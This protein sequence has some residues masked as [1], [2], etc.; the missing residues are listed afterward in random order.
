[1]GGVFSHFCCHDLWYLWSPTRRSR[2]PRYSDRSDYV[3]DEVAQQASLP[4]SSSS[5]PPI[6]RED[7][8]QYDV[9][10]S[11]R[12]PDTRYGFIS[13]LHQALEDK[14]IITFIDSEGLEKGR[15]VDELFGYIERSKIFVP[16]FSKGYANS[17][18]CLKEI[19]KIMECKRLV[20]PVFFHVE[21]TDVRHQTGPF[22]D[23][24]RD[25]LEKEKI[26]EEEV[27]N[28]RSALKEAGKISGH[29]LDAAA[30]ERTEAKVV[31]LICKRVQELIGRVPFGVQPIGIDS[32]I[33][34][35]IM[36][37]RAQANGVCK[38]GICG[39]GGIGKTTTAKAIYDKLYSEFDGGSFIQDIREFAERKGMEAV[40]EK[41]IRDV[42]KQDN[43]Q[44][45]NSVEQGRVIIKQRLERKRVLIILDNIVNPYQLEAL[46]GDYIAHKPEDLFGEGSKIIVTARDEAI[47][48]GFGL[49]GH[50]IYYPQELK[51]PWSLKLFHRHAF[52]HEQ[53]PP[54]ALLKLAEEAT[55]IAGGLPLVLELFGKAFSGLKKPEEWKNELKNLRMNPPTDIMKNLRWSYDELDD[56]EKKV[57]LDIACFLVGAKRKLVAYLWDDI[58][59]EDA[60]LVLQ[61][62]SLLSVDDEDRFRM[63][64]R[65]QEMGR[66]IAGG[67]GNGDNCRLCCG[68][69]TPIMTMHSEEKEKVQGIVLKMEAQSTSTNLSTKEF[70]GMYNLRLLHLYHVSFHERAEINHFPKK[71]KWLRWQGCPLESVVFNGSSFMN[72]AI[73]ELSECIICHLKLHKLN[74]LKVLNLSNCE[75]LQATPDFSC[76][77]NLEKLFLDNC[78]KLSDIHESVC[79][80]ESL[81]TWSMRN[82]ESVKKLPEEHRC[83]ISNLSKL[84]ELNLQGCEKIGSL[85]RLPSSLKVLVLKGCKML[86]AVHGFDNL[87]FIEQLYM[88]GCRRINCNLMTRLF[89]NKT[90]TYLEELSISGS[91]TTP[92]SEKFLLAVPLCSPSSPLLLDHLK[93]YGYSTKPS[94][95]SNIYNKVCVKDMEDNQTIY[96]TTLSAHRD[97]YDEIG[98]SL[99]YIVS[100]SKYDDINFFPNLYGPRLVWVST[101]DSF[102]LTSVDILLRSANQWNKNN[103]KLVHVHEI[104]ANLLEE[105][106]PTFEYRTLEF[107]VMFSC[108]DD[109]DRDFIS[110]ICKVLE[111]DGISCVLQ[112]KN[113]EES[114]V[115]E[116]VKCIERSA[117]CVPIFSKQFIQSKWCLD[118]IAKMIECEKS[119]MPIYFHVHPSEVISRV[120]YEMKFLNHEDEGQ[121]EIFNDWR[122]VLLA[123]FDHQFIYE[124]SSNVEE[125]M[126][127]V[128]DGISATLNSSAFSLPLTGIG[129]RVNDVMKMV[130]KETRMVGICGE[131]GIGKTAIAKAMYDQRFHTSVSDVFI[132]HVGDLARTDP[133][134]SSRNDRLMH[135][136]EDRY[137][138]NLM[139]NSENNMG[140]AIFD[141]ADGLD[142]HQS[143][144]MFG[145]ESL[146]GEGT[147][148]IIIAKD[149]N[150]LYK[151]GLSDENIYSVSKLN[152]KQ[153]LRLF[154]YHAFKGRRPKVEIIPMAW[155]ATQF[156]GGLPL[157]LKVLVSLFSGL[158]DENEWKSILEK[159]SRAPGEGVDK[160]LEVSIGSL[161]PHEQQV[162]FDIAFLNE[163]P[164][165]MWKDVRC[166][167]GNTIEFLQQRCLISVDAENMPRMHDL[168]R[169][170][171]R[172][173]IAQR[174]FRCLR[175]MITD[176]LDLDHLH[177]IFLDIACCLIGCE[178]EFATYMWE[179][180]GYSPAHAI[181]VLHDRS[182][183][184]VDEKGRL[185]M[186]DC[187][188]DVGT[189]IIKKDELNSCSHWNENDLLQTLGDG[190]ESCNDKIECINA[191]FTQRQRLV[192]MPAMG[193][194]R[195]LRLSNCDFEY[196]CLRSDLKNL[197]WLRMEMCSVTSRVLCDGD[198]F[199]NLLVLQLYDCRMVK[200]NAVGANNELQKV[201][202][203]AHHRKMYYQMT[204]FHKLKVL[205]IVKCKDVES[206]SLHFS[207][208][209]SLVKLVIDLEGCSKWTES[210]EDLAALSE[211]ILSDSTME[212]LPDCIFKLNQLQTFCISD[213]GMLK[214]L[215]QLPGSLESLEL[216][217]CYEI[218]ELPPLPG[219][220]KTLKIKWCR[221]S[222]LPQLPASL[223]TL[224]LQGCHEISELP[225][226]PGSLKTLKIKWCTI[227]HLPQL[228]SSLITLDT[229]HCFNLTWMA[230]ISGLRDL[231]I[232]NLCGCVKLA[233]VPGLQNLK[234][235]PFITPPSSYW[236]A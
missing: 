200:E 133:G 160:I 108:T 207:F 125:F 172:R 134:F 1:M 165:A 199:E 59:F 191:R 63:H 190:K 205:E 232:L 128:R 14:G 101:T 40:Q 123:Q 132:P 10:L 103:S 136:I 57:F 118:S 114:K 8:F 196:R 106:D 138:A 79:H 43:D 224:Q 65:I 180:C 95:E 131:S 20:I 152:N 105:S 83:S 173:R 117:I 9:F 221:I 229:S 16:V 195:V 32:Q 219:S 91:T 30:P 220:L 68:D 54:L 90:F 149:R 139:L 66:W 46:C 92:E 18:W 167:S 154:V 164:S 121:R 67:E 146:F 124:S 217:G 208:M 74:G 88:D 47:L 222:H 111:E 168:I 37:L 35:V 126:T 85:P 69:E 28:W 135:F 178:K 110:K 177:K 15:K 109:V 206:A 197:R 44:H 212:K 82:C 50:Q 183:V 56:D 182:I 181:R 42:L 116:L 157:A 161:L 61:G 162:F 120:E 24:F 159:L 84:E 39:M 234:P 55:G 17:K 193:N 87:E 218:S 22:A 60:I 89:Q 53:P 202:E 29:H 215:P 201:R 233:S 11:F 188:R 51:H 107:D 77:P 147:K 64:D 99:S 36:M 94:Y 49:T 96:K 6:I 194:L 13:H 5:A 231:K 115:E 52:K 3:G 58:A 78:S 179:D 155:K 62:R 7:K 226:L 156:A 142:E 23:A 81:T 174:R 12:G 129:Y 148:K 216:E 2:S 137:G 228:P 31:T 204:V 163:R 210:L 34:E 225:P 158:T 26:D 209:P 72:L 151:Y 169:D 71:L 70:Q 93:F 185:K 186:D 112:V 86:K 130:E 45:I 213:C 184:T 104:Q 119:I 21:P 203:E 48:L 4:P 102:Q 73:L 227:S 153:S 100:L 19:A 198:I 25:Y 189:S 145:V 113:G 176:G 75:N 187:I 170:W 236:R 41:L 150:D 97:I 27:R 223:E 141:D 122:K 38:I 235:R 98:D 192:R 214:H 171:G 211:L 127:V 230:D 144:Q 175:P 166:S 33:A 143:E 76:T 80:L 140:F